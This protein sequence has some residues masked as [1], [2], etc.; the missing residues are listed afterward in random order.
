MSIKKERASTSK[1]PKTQGRKVSKKDLLRLR[2][3]SLSF[4]MYYY[5]KKDF[6]VSQV[7][8][9]LKSILN[10][11][12]GFISVSQQPDRVIAEFLVSFPVHVS[13]IDSFGNIM[14]MTYMGQEK[15]TVIIKPE[16]RIIE[17]RGSKRIAKKAI[18]TLAKVLEVRINPL[19]FN[20]G[21]MAE[22]Y[23]KANTIGSVLIT[24]M[25]NPYLKAIEI[26]GE[27]VRNAPE[28]GVFTRRQKGKISRFRGAFEF[29]SGQILTT[30]IDADGS[31]II[32]KK[33]EGLYALDVDWFV[34]TLEETA[35]AHL[36]A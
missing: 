10:S 29:P 12:E 28:I 31:A 14:P 19:G 34:Q 21:G 26:S 17:V 1:R 13:G 16:L 22:L 5:E 6:T 36:E 32:Y 18:Y 15:G 35:L 33:G 11:D 3:L 9:V 27:S 24:D 8:K 2:G 30:T 23:K 7:V 25:E 20:N 4:R